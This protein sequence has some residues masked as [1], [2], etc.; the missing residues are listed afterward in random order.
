MSLYNIDDDEEKVIIH[1]SP[2][3]LL[4]TAN[5]KYLAVIY[6][7][8]EQ[9]GHYYLFRIY[10]I[11]ITNEI[12]LGQWLWV[13][14]N[15]YKNIQHC[16]DRL[17]KHYNI[18]QSIEKNIKKNIALGIE[19]YL[20]IDDTGFIYILS[21]DCV[22]QYSINNEEFLDRFSFV[23]SI[24]FKIMSNLPNYALTIQVISKQQWIILEDLHRQKFS[25]KISQSK[26]SGK[27]IHN[28]ENLF[29]FETQT[30]EIDEG[31]DDNWQ[32]LSGTLGQMRSGK[33]LRKLVFAGMREKQFIIDKTQ[34]SFCG[35]IDYANLFKFDLLTG[36]HKITPTQFNY[37]YQDVVKVS[38][39]AIVYSNRG[40]NQMVFVRLK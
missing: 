14:H 26:L 5:E 18:S 29:Y 28:L 38:K 20:D 1:G 7:W 36:K 17:Q 22:Y 39:N 13:R 2:F 19:K 33:I 11:R 35:I 3:R 6:E 21:N 4:I 15:Y 31:M 40:G 23:N 16:F 10:D 25:K 24:D 27:E 30:L 32:I 34:V 12:A 8:G 37:K 9:E